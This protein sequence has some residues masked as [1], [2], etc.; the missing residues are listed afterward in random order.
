M[1]AGASISLFLSCSNEVLD[2]TLQSLGLEDLVTCARVC[3]R[4]ADVVFS[5]LGR[6]ATW[7]ALF[8]GPAS[9]DCSW[10]WSVACNCSAD[11]ERGVIM[12]SD[13]AVSPVLFA[14]RRVR[15]F[16]RWTDEL[17]LPSC[18]AAV[19]LPV[20]R[21]RPSRRRPWCDVVHTL[22][23]HASVL[24]LFRR[25]V[26]LSLCASCAE[27]RDSELAMFSLV[28]RRWPCG[29]L[30]VLGG[31]SYSSVEDSLVSLGVD[32]CLCSA[33]SSFRRWPCEAG[34]APTVFLDGEV[35]PRSVVSA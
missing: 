1:M 9:W 15:A 27:L 2:L 31:A 22:P 33:A 11:V 28:D 10:T 14:S 6:E 23:K 30:P 35:V 16:L 21:V 32:V 34:C 3:R 29:C 19:L 5:L 24:C 20:S 13:V 4:L 18:V 12:G 8:L 25:Q 7:K 17:V 26:G